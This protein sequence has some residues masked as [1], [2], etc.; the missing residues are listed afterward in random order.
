M[1]KRLVPVSGS[2]RLPVLPAVEWEW[3]WRAAAAACGPVRGGRPP[4]IASSSARAAARTLSPRDPPGIDHGSRRA[5]RRRRQASLDWRDSLYGSCHDDGEGRLSSWAWAWA[6]PMA[7]ASWARW[8][9][10][11]DYYE[12]KR[13]RSEVCERGNF[14]QPSPDLEQEQ[15]QV[16]V[17]GWKLRA[18]PPRKRPVQAATGRQPASPWH[19]KPHRGQ[20]DR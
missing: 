15:G 14:A 11:T 8:N 4:S 9:T 20:N 6:W 5:G 18:P 19:P 1:G 7:V 17:R 10:M 13:A 12:V 3:A 16:H 2:F